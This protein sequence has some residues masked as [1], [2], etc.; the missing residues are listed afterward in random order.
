MFLRAYQSKDNPSGTILT[1]AEKRR[2]EC[3]DD[4]PPTPLGGRQLVLLKLEHMRTNPVRAR[5]FS[6]LEFN[7]IVWWGDHRMEEL[8]VNWDNITNNLSVL[9]R[10]RVR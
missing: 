5:T 7:R 10:E 9:C 6:N 4:N 8:L 2:Q 1:T 3:Y